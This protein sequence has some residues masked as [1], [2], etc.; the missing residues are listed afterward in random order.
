[1]LLKG[2][3]G[4]VY[5]DWNKYVKLKDMSNFKVIQTRMHSSRMLTARSLTMGMYLSQ[6][7]YLSQGY[8]PREVYLSWGGYLPRGGTCPG[9][10]L[11]RY[12]PPVD[13]ILDTRY[14]KYYLAPTLLRAVKILELLSLQMKWKLPPCNSSFNIQ[15]KPW[16][17]YLLRVPV[18]EGVPVRE[19]GGSCTCPGGTCSGGCTCPGGCTCAGGTCPG[20]V[21]ARGVYL[22]G[23]VWNG[24]FRHAIILSTF[25]W[26]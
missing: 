11:P 9:G 13:R 10:Y 26:N 2:L 15:L 21:P 25:N 23:G 6:G 19:G 14:W 17:V 12:S 20:G 1:M 24:N 8:L 4:S 7:V 5:L 18:L 3:K 22:A 16:G